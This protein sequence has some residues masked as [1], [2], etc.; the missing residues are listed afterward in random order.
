M[1]TFLA[2]EPRAYREVIAAAL[3]E[4]RPRIEVFITE[5]EDLDAAV[6]QR[7]PHL[8][9]CSQLTEIVRT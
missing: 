2:N 8:V 3:R 6:L 4:L 9:V 1:R 5:P 7:T